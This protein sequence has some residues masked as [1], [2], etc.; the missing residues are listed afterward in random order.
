MFF[1]RLEYNFSI[2]ESSLDGSHHALLHHLRFVK[3]LYNFESI[4]LIP[5]SLDENWLIRKHT[6]QVLTVSK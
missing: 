5:Y 3:E 2:S 6:K 4:R 1:T